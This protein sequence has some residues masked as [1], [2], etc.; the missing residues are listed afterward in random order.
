[1]VGINGVG[2][3]ETTPPEVDWLYEVG[4]CKDTPPDLLAL[5]A[6]AYADAQRQRLRRRMHFVFIVVS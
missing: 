6:F 2:L 3:F 5:S 4:P 1:M